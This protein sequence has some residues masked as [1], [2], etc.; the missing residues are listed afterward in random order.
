MTAAERAAEDA[1]AEHFNEYP[2]YDDVLETVPQRQQRQAQAAAKRPPPSL[3]ELRT[4]VQDLT[5]ASGGATDA[6]M[7][8]R[9]T[10]ASRP[11]AGHRVKVGE[12]VAEFLG[13]FSLHDIDR[14]ESHHFI[15]AIEHLGADT[16]IQQAVQRHIDG[17]PQLGR[18]MQQRWHDL[19]ERHKSRG[20]N[21][22][23]L[24]RLM[25]DRPVALARYLLTGR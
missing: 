19:R 11:Q 24:L 18:E 6:N 25:R 5:R 8:E 13:V 9:T 10:A 1:R 7:K 17:N 14:F 2:R 23:G 22:Q 15:Q 4:R 21:D 20:F 12:R 16:R 3:E